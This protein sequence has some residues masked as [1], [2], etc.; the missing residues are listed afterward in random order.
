MN[1]ILKDMLR[2]W[3]RYTAPDD[4]EVAENL[5]Q[6]GHLGDPV[7]SGCIV[8]VQVWI[9]RAVPRVPV[10]PLIWERCCRTGA[11]RVLTGLPPPLPPLLHQSLPGPIR[12]I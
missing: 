3:T 10:R 2:E 8:T 9:S 1:R 12:H 5:E 4:Y 11:R 6:Q 7:A